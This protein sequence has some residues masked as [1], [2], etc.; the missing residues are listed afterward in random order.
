MTE[1]T[2]ARHLQW[3]KDRALEFADQGDDG[4]ALSSLM[5]DLALHPETAGLA[6]VVL[7]LGWPQAMAG[8]FARR[9]QDLRDFIE[10]IS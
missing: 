10:G 5:Q 7:E 4:G 6:Q 9:P 1:L 2:R 3:C 8:V